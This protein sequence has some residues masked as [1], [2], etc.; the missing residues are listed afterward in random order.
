M[1][2]IFQHDLPKI[3]KKHQIKNV[4]DGYAVNFLIPNGHAILAT[5]EAEKNV[6]KQKVIFEVG[7]KIQDNLLH[8]N[9]ET[10]SNTK[11][12]IISKSNDKGHLFS[13]IHKEQ[14]AVELLAQTNLEVPA[15]LIQMEKPIKEIGE[16]KIKIG[17]EDKTAI[18]IVEIVA[19]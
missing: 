16:H 12:R 6:A 7:K 2:V 8:K 19:E 10:I 3:G 5:P 18:L 4:S 17:T 1:K 13:G 11:L 9:L 14:I 15:D